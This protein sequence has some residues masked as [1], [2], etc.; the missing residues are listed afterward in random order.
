MSPDANANTS[1]LQPRV[2]DAILPAVNS[3]IPLNDLHPGEIAHVSGLDAVT[4]LGASD[5]EVLQLLARLRDLG[6]V[7]GARCEVLARM[8][9]GGD[10]LVVKIGGSTFALRRIEASAVRVQRVQQSLAGH[11]SFPQNASATA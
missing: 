10:P 11:A 7:N 6:F 3:S 8:W 2:P 5:P 1:H 4:A 9:F